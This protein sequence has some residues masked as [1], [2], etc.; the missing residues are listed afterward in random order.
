MN[1]HFIH[2]NFFFDDGFRE[3]TYMTSEVQKVL[4][5]KVCCCASV[6][7]H[8]TLHMTFDVICDWP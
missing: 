4:M 3:R 2:A 7:C 6:A 5:E 8:V 1:R